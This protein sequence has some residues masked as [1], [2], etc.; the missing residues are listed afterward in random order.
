M[1]RACW[2]G[3]TTSASRGESLL[4]ALTVVNSEGVGAERQNETEIFEML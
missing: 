1:I 2:M 4:V 3:P